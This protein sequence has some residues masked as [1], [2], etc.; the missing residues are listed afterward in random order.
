MGVLVGRVFIY[1]SDTTGQIAGVRKSISPIETKKG[2][3]EGREGGKVGK[4][5]GIKL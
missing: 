2:G 4:D 5:K 1:E 3:K